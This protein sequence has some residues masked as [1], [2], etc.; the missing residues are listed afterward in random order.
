M[1]SKEEP[2][3]KDVL[4]WPAGTVLD[5]QPRPKR[6]SSEGS[7]A[8]AIELGKS[9]SRRRQNVEFSLFFFLGSVL[10]ILC[11]QWALKWVQFPVHKHPFEVGLF[12]SVPIFL[13]YILLRIVDYM[14]TN[15]V[16][17]VSRDENEHV[18]D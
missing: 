7:A 10:W 13:V 6:R 16:A 5:A 3:T 18:V 17:E 11:V 15:R 1:I 9:A 4:V 8:D 12:Y 14:T 2:N